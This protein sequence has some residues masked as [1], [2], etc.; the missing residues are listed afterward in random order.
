MKNNQFKKVVRQLI[1][2]ECK[3]FDFQSVYVDEGK[4]TRIIYIYTLGWQFAGMFYCWFNGEG[5]HLQFS[6][7][8]TLPIIVH[9]VKDV[10]VKYCDFNTVVETIKETFD[11][12]DKTEG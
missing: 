12:M 3:T 7:L 5:V 2:K 11:I 4:N 9:K 6:N 1:D 10:R 8:K